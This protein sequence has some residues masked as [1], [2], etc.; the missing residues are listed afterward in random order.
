[1]LF[2]I[3]SSAQTGTASRFF[4]RPPWRASR[5]SMRTA[6]FACDA[7]A[8]KS[9]CG[10]LR[11]RYHAAA[12]SSAPYTRVHDGSTDNGNTTPRQPEPCFITT[13][14]ASEEATPTEHCV[15]REASWLASSARQQCLDRLG[16]RDIC[17]FHPLRTRQTVS[18]SCCGREQHDYGWV[19]T[20]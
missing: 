7:E 13:T 5:V 1:M 19:S 2:F 20:D 12:S 17:W 14:T 9:G 15:S 11:C 6:R 16:A 4:F 18:R 10:T 3:L 8:V